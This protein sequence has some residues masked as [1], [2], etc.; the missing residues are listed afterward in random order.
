MHYTDLH[1][2]YFSEGMI[3]RCMLSNVVITTNEQYIALHRG[4]RSDTS[5]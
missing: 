1:Q 2:N 3:Y 4:E 5:F